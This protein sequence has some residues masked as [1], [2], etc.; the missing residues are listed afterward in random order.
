M[1]GK[2]FCWLHFLISFCDFLSLQEK[3]SN[4]LWQL[5][6]KKSKGS[7]NTITIESQ[8][9]FHSLPISAVFNLLK[10]YKKK[11]KDYGILF[12]FGLVGYINGTTCGLYQSKGNYLKAVYFFVN[13]IPNIK[14]L[15]CRV[16]KRARKDYLCLY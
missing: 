10:H 8:Y 15:L 3:K 2:G 5:H 14:R 1:E 11:K 9:L 12:F 13:P 6:H 4:I 16:T 7:A